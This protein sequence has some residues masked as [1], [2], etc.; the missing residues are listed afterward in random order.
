VGSRISIG[1]GI[2]TADRESFRRFVARTGELKPSVHMPSFGVLP[3]GDLEAL[4]AYL[5]SLQ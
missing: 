1:A 2:L 4:A 3:P 5:E